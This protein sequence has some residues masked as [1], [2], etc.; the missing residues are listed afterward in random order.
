MPDLILR[1]H[2]LHYFPGNPETEDRMKGLPQGACVKVTVPASDS[3]ARNLAQ[4]NLYWA[5]LGKVVANQSHFQTADDLHWGLKIRLGL[6]DEI[7]LQ[8]GVHLKPKSIALGRMKQHDF[9]K[10]FREAMQFIS[11]EVIPGLD[12]QALIDEINDMVG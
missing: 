10:F 6:V 11:T 7:H 3:Q 2:G 5:V 1:K 12:S 4:L 9:D 8:D